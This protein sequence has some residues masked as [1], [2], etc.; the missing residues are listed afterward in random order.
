MSSFVD[1]AAQDLMSINRRQ[2]TRISRIDAATIR[3]R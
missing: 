3:T 2:F 1:S